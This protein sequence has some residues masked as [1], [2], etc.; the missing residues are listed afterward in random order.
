MADFNWVYGIVLGMTDKEARQVQEAWMVHKKTGLGLGEQCGRCNT[1]RFTCEC[2]LKRWADEF[3]LREF[4]Y[5]AG[6]ILDRRLV[7]G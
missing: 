6:N 2:V 5:E 4:G 7:F 3:I 1:N